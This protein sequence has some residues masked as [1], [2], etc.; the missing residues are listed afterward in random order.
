MIGYI[1]QTSRRHIL[2]LED[3]VEFRHESARSL[4]NQRQLGTHFNDFASALKASL[5]EDPDVILVGE[6]RDPETMALAITAAETGH[7]VFA[8]L[9]TN[10]AAKSIDRIL[11]SFDSSRQAQMR[12]MLSE[13]LRLVISQK[14][15]PTANLKGRICVMDI[16]VNTSAVSNLI[17]EGKTFQLPSIMQT[18]R[19]DGMQLSDY[20]LLEAVRSGMVTG[21]VAWEHASDKNLFAQY[22]PRDVGGN[23]QAGS[24]NATNPAFKK[25]GTGV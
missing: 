5:R 11:D 18:G 9:H 15:I 7:L 16:L 12:A 21:I 10:S 19:K 1:N 3:P 2:T 24:R 22:A 20:Q 25:T 14:L 17:R 13:S 4:V 8:T 6:M 23:T